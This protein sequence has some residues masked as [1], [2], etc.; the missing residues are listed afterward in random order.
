MTTK[1]LKNF[2]QH[3]ICFKGAVV[4]HTS[5]YAKM[6]LVKFGVYCKIGTPGSDPSK[7]G[8]PNGN[9]VEVDLDRKSQRAQPILT[10][11]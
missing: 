1:L 10:R 6:V 7:V 11:R 3:A 5:F 4:G 9:V 2:I 8:L